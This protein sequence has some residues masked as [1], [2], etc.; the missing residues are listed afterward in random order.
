M[1]ESRKKEKKSE[2]RNKPLVFC[3][4]AHVETTN[5]CDLQICIM[6]R[7]S[8]RTRKEKKKGWAT[9]N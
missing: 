5:L 7:G 2:L 8:H 3:R 6:M 1:D 9:R 4:D